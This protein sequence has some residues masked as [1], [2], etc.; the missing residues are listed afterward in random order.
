MLTIN[1]RVSLVVTAPNGATYMTCGTV[2][3]A[4]PT[5]YGTYTVLTNGEPGRQSRHERYIDALTVIPKRS[6]RLQLREFDP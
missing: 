1:T 5:A 6:L 2:V 4:P 3:E